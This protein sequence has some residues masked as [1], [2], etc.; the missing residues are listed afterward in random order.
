MKRISSFILSLL[1]V[2]ATL[3]IIS[4]TLAHPVSVDGNSNDWSGIPPL[5][6]N[7]YTVDNGELVW[8]DNLGDARTDLGDVSNFDITEFRVTGDSENI[9]FLLRFDNITATWLP[10]VFIAIDS[11]LDNKGNDWLPEWSD[12]KVSSSAKWENVIEVCLENTGVWDT[13]WNFRT[14]MAAS[15]ISDTNEAIEISVQRSSLGLSWPATLRITVAVFKDNSGIPADVYETSDALDVVTDVPGNTWLEVID[16]V[17]DYY[18]VVHFNSSGDV[19][20]GDVGSLP[21]TANLLPPVGV[22][23][24]QKVFPVE[25][26]W[27]P[28][29]WENVIVVVTDNDMDLENI[30]LMAYENSLDN[31][32]PD[33]TRNHYTWVASKSGGSWQFSCP[34][35]STYIDTAGCSVQENSQTKTYTATFKVRVAK[36]AAPGSWDLY[37][38]AVDENK[39]ENYLENA[40][41]ISVAAYL[42]MTLSSDQLTFTGYPG[43]SIPAS[44]NPL[45]V[46]VTSNTYSNIQVKAAGDWVSNGNTILAGATK[47]RGE[48][49]WISLST[50]YQNV[51][52]NITCGEGVQ[53]DIEWRLDI[54]S[55]AVPGTYTNTFYIRVSG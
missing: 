20:V 36:T 2:S 40:Y 22:I 1:V 12:T 38:R 46:S 11:T 48:G 9:Y 4:P 21:A 49:D 34:L 18:L 32:A 14:G 10:F 39:N 43:Q 35:G 6:V 29:I 52:T 26:L 16:N 54:P 51:W 53:K 7:S 50:S 45:T 25:K 28:Y 47:A 15:W 41:A 37:A 17:I 5:Q 27:T 42:E 30:H 3:S 13:E 8:R 31:T 23:Q 55:D 33:S 19:V 24:V 44:Q